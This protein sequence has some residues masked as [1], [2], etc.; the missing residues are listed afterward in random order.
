MVQNQANGLGDL[1][2]NL[3][4]SHMC[5]ADQSEAQDQYFMQELAISDGRDWKNSQ[6]QE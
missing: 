1:W 6:Q 2:T 4:E 3:S 5:R